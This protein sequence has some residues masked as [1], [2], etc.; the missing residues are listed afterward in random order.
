MGHAY[1]QNPTNVLNARTRL[2]TLAGS[3]VT[4][5]R[6]NQDPGCHSGP[7]V[8]AIKRPGSVMA[9]CSVGANITKVNHTNSRLA[10]PAALTNE[11][12][13]LMVKRLIQAWLTSM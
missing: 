4:L 11:R 1:L 5:R 7:P 12:E 3:V 9:R 13:T 10:G 6:K 8:I 2:I